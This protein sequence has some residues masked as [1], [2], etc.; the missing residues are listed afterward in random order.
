MRKV[1]HLALLALTGTL[2]ACSTQVQVVYQTDP[3]GAAVYQGGQLL[4]NAPVAVPY[5]LTD[6]DRQNGY[7][8]IDA[9]SVKWESGAEA[10]IPGLKADLKQLGWNQQYS[11]LR[12]N[13]PGL[14]ADLK[15]AEEK[16]KQDILLRNR[17]VQAMMK[18]QEGTKPKTDADCYY[19]RMRPE[20]A[21]AC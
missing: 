1:I 20:A 8:I 5:P 7:K 14:D 12:P 2:C 17:T 16:Q 13:V 4:G 18:T 15:K 19:A 6:A 11:F 21:Q 9:V 10:S 3:P